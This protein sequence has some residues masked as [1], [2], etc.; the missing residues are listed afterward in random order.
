MVA[1]CAT[2]D[3]EKQTKRIKNEDTRF[4]VSINIVFGKN[5]NDRSVKQHD[6]KFNKVLNNKIH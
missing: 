3:I 2:N 5:R 6:T 1:S 4:M